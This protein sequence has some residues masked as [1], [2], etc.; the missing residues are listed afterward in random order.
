MRQ[1]NEYRLGGERGFFRL[2][3][4]TDYSSREP[5]KYATAYAL[6]SPNGTAVI[7]DDYCLGL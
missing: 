3:A 7:R 1:V 2:V 4:A 6:E 5:L